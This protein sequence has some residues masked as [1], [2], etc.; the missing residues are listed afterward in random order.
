MSAIEVV[1]HVTLDGVMQAPAHPDEDRR[2]GFEHGGWASD[3]SDHVQAEY[4]GA[5]MS[6]RGDGALLFGRWTY[7]KMQSAWTQRPQDDP[8]R[9]V[10]ENST[11]YV[12][13]RSDRPVEWQNSV[14][15]EGDAVATVRELKASADRNL[16]ILGSGELIQALL[17]HGLIDALLLTIHPLV[18]GSG[19]RLFGDDG[20]LA[21]F[22]LAESTPTTTGVLICRYEAA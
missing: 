6:R 1:N 2:G 10:L 19:R 15:L 7:D 3:Y 8:I 22:R 18:L 11:K 17:P 5:R 16:V 13:S 4:M 21:R 14:L 20:A 12:A 9:Q